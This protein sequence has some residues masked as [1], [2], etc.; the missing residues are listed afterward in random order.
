[1]LVTELAD[2]A[3]RGK[4]MSLDEACKLHPKFETELR[5][6]WGTI[7]VTDAAA[8]EQGSSF[9]QSSDVAAPQLELPCD[10]G[11][12]ILEEEIGRGGRGIVYNAVRTSNEEPVAIKMILKGDFATEA[13]R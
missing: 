2:E 9:L 7:I 1:M 10:F 13:D 5:E 11:N 8:K 4:T 3:N 12:Y 6:L